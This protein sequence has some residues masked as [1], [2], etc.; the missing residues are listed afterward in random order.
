[1]LCPDQFIQ[2]FTRSQQR[3]AR[4]YQTVV[5]LAGSAE[6]ITFQRLVLALNLI[7]KLKQFILGREYGS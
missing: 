4:T 5:L 6:P 1:M 2:P 3:A 7:M